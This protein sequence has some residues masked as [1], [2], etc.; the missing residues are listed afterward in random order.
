MGGGLSGKEGGAAPMLPVRRRSSQLRGEAGVVAWPGLREEVV[1]LH[2]SCHR[3]EGPAP[4]VQLML[5][6]EAGGEVRLG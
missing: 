5:E 3:G 2:P 6:V 4:P 1:K